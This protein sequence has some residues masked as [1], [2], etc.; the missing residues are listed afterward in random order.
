MCVGCRCLIYQ[1]IHSDNI[2]HALFTFLSI[3][4]HTF[5]GVKIDTDL[6]NLDLDYMVGGGAVGIDLRDLAADRYANQDL[7]NAELGDLVSLVLLKNFD[8]PLWA[9]MTTNWERLPL[10]NSQIQYACSVAFAHFKIDW[11]GSPEAWVRQVHSTLDRDQFALF[12]TICWN[13]WFS[14][15]KSLW[16][17]KLS[18]PGDVFT[19]ATSFLFSFQEATP[20]R[21][22]SP[23]G[24]NSAM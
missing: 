20:T 7:R 10:A 13:L 22:I 4:Y 1:V 24:F 21:L 17:A 15:N 14:R 2:P 16:E 9:T 19:L 5:V 12:L 6:N 11:S 3:P 18:T 8:K 23:P